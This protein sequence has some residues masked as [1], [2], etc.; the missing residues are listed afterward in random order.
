MPRRGD[1]STYVKLHG[2]RSRCRCLLPAAAVTIVAAAVTVTAAAECKS[3]THTHAHKLFFRHVLLHTR[4]SEMAAMQF[5]G[6]IQCNSLCCLSM[7]ECVVVRVCVRLR[8][9][10]R[11]AESAASRAV[12]RGPTAKAQLFCEITA[13]Q[14]RSKQRRHDGQRQQ[15]WN[16]G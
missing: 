10:R 14:Q 1:M 9:A 4:A 2:S 11:T 16:V 5:T 3:N 12:A 7:C 15:E 13:E 6:Q 8:A